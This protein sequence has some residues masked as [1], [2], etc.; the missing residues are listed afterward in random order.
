MVMVVSFAAVAMLFFSVFPIPWQWEATELLD[1][2]PIDFAHGTVKD[3]GMIVNATASCADHPFELAKGAVG[4]VVR[5]SESCTLSD[6]QA[7]KFS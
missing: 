2:G 6:I 4:V 7:K 1:C 3:L 5:V